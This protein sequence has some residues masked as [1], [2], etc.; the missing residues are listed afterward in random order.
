MKKRMLGKLALVL[1]VAASVQTAA[2]GVEAATVEHIH[3]YELSSYETTYIY[4]DE[5]SHIARKIY[6]ER[7]TECGEIRTTT[8][9]EAFSHNMTTER[10][11]YYNEWCI[12][13]Y[14]VDCGHQ[15]HIGPENS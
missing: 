8:R 2:I 6:E 10:V 1:M 11:F 12:R 13:E 7:C 5:D 3:N 15:F 14:C 9:E 4:R